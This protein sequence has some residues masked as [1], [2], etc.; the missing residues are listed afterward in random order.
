MIEGLDE[1]SGDEEDDSE[2]EPG[3]PDKVEVS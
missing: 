3:L 2:S 1:V